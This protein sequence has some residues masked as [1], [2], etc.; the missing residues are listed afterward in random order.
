MRAARPRTLVFRFAP[1]QHRL[2]HLFAARAWEGWQARSRL[3]F[4][5]SMSMSTHLCKNG[6]SGSANRFTS[7]SHSVRSC[8]RPYPCLKSG[9]STC[10][11]FSNLAVSCPA[12]KLL[13][14]SAIDRSEGS[15]FIV[16][17]L[18][19][20]LWYPFYGLHRIFYLSRVRCY[21]RLYLDLYLGLS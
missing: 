20:P 14:V 5:A 6:L 2:R 9:C 10:S 3:I 15:N 19:A 13:C 21:P 12:R 16:G 17:A 7:S 18:S 4:H 8:M 11:I 1:F